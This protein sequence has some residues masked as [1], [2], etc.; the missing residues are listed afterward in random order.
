MYKLPCISDLSRVVKFTARSGRPD[1]HCSAQDLSWFNSIKVACITSGRFRP[2]VFV[3]KTKFVLCNDDWKY[4]IQKLWF[5]LTR[6]KDLFLQ[7]GKIVSF[8]LEV[9]L[10][11]KINL[12]SKDPR[13]SLLKL[14]LNHGRWLRSEKFTSIYIIYIRLVPWQSFDLVRKWEC[15]NPLGWLGRHGLDKL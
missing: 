5:E 12:R 3:I 15:T 4:S 11:Q 10:S 1:L 8:S 9:K 2:L 6:P 13:M 14:S 7:L